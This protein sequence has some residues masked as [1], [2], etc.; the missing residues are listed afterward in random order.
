MSTVPG[1]CSREKALLMMDLIKEN[2]S[3]CCLEIGVFS[4]M[5]LY[6]IAKALS[7]QG[8]GQVFGIDAWDALEAIAGFNT[9]DP[10][11]EWWSRLDFNHFYHQ[12]LDLIHQHELDKH[13]KVLRQA[14]QKAVQLFD[15]D[16]VDFIHFDGNHNAEYA[17]HDIVSYFPKIK[18]GGYILLNDPNWYGMQQALVFLL[19]RAD[20]ISAFSPSAPYM[21]FRK[22]GQCIQN[23][24]RL[25]IT[26]TL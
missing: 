9:A 15:D 10:N 8:S 24:N 1:W 16:T 3:E 5:S 11:F 17:Y 12:T 21:L 14:S 2:R 4:G 19:E 6:P 7:Y 25:S 18:D 13:C 22:N 26:K 20:V 23:A